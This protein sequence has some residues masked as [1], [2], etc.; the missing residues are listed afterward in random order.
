MSKLTDYGTLVLARLATSRELTTTAALA[1]TT[2]LPLPTVRKL[3]KA[4]ASAG[5]VTSERGVAG[6]YRLS[7]SAGTISAADILTALEGP[8]HLTECSAATH[9]CQLE[10]TCTVGSAWQRING[11]IRSAL[12]AVTLED[13]V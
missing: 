13:L 12:E 2:G 3:L 5:L 11:H 9:D 7:R 4:L 6:G 10:A 1:E 8:L